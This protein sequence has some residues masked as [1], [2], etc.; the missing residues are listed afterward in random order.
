MYSFLY[1]VLERSSRSEIAGQLCRPS[2]ILNS[3]LFEYICPCY[4]HNPGQW[5]AGK[6]FTFGER[7]PL[8]HFRQLLKGDSISPLAIK[9]P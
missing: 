3:M 7:L 6:E 2:H 8:E 9:G 5:T 1:F 4:A